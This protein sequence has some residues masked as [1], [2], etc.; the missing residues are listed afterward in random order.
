M[1][2]TAAARWFSA[3][4]LSG[5]L[6]LG[7]PLLAESCGTPQLQTAFMADG[8]YSIHWQEGSVRWT[9]RMPE[10]GRVERY[11]D[12]DALGEYCELRFQGEASD[13]TDAIRVYPAQGI[14]S[15]TVQT[16]GGRPEFPRLAGV[17]AGW[18]RLGFRVA[19]FAP[20]AFN[21]LPHQGPWVLFDGKLRTVVV[22]PADHFF[23]SDLQLRQGIFT[24]GFLS[25]VAEVP[26]HTRHTTVLTFGTGVHTTLTAWGHALQA[27]AARPPVRNDAGPLLRGLSYWTDNGAYYYYRFDPKL[28]YTGT[29]LAVADKFHQDGVP[30]HLMQLDSWFYPKGPEQQWQVRHWEHGAGG[31]Y[32]YEPDKELFPDGIGAFQKKLDLPMAV[33]GRWV[34]ASSPYRQM[35]K[36]SGNVIIDPRYWQQTAAWLHAAN[37][38]VYEQDWLGSFAQA[39]PN[40]TAPEAYHDEM[41]HAMRQQ[42]I[43]L[44]YCMPAPADYLQGVRYPNLT[45]IRTSDDRFDRAKWDEF[46]Y[47]SQ[48][49]YALGIWPWSDVFMSSETAN[50]VLATLSSGPV[51]V[52]D[53]INQ[54]DAKNLLR[55]ARADGVLVKPDFGIRPLDRMYAADA[56]GTATPMLAVAQ[57]RQPA[58]AITYLFAYARHQEASAA[59]TP[60]EL[61][62]RGSVL[63][64]NWRTGD[65]G[66]V[67]AGD[68]YQ[69]PLTDGWGYAVVTPI[70]LAGLALVGDPQMIATAGRK[71]LAAT[72]VAGSHSLKIALEFAA[73]ERAQ[74][75]V[76]YALRAPRVRVTA[77]RLQAQRYDAAS[78]L[79]HL[80]LAPDTRGAAQVQVIPA[81]GQPASRQR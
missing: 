73:G 54:I 27:W 21:Q 55:A 42:G 75:L 35:Y 57:T 34:D 51:G 45:T 36:M 15:L 14:V 26:A 10:S 4:L 39:E 19:P 59:F 37:I 3:C 13:E 5:L 81:S 2:H 30:L 47:D 67:S 33:H 64:Y 79:L 41:A 66:L 76:L 69:M 68:S 48:I 62:Y 70:N 46:L 29:L 71:R 78:H 1:P 77:G 20:F 25:S 16:A 53:A 17:S 23:V 24:S 31:A 6:I 80:T 58:G 7:S 43:A 38:V 49:A 9:G 52:G 40:F 60:S 18:H 50:L 72:A 44:Q 11:S 63:V 32:R 22:S 28:G 8:S 61:G 12:H 65:G 56:A 74:P